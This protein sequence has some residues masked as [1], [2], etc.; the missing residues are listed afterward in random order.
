MKK[1]LIVMF[2]IMFV[3]LLLTNF[4]NAQDKNIKLVKGRKTVIKGEVS[5]QKDRTYFFKAKKGQNFTIKLTGRDAVFI[6]AAQH[7]FDSEN[8]T[9]ETKSWSGKLP[10]ADSGEYAIRLSSNYKVASYTL[11][12]TLK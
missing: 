7:N 10:N 9:E 3:G 6:L 1:K 2:G 12:I 4:A 5:D 11:E 8:F